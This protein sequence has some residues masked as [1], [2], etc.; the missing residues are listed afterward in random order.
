MRDERCDG[1]SNATDLDGGY[2]RMF[3]CQP[4]VL[5]CAQHD[6]YAEQRKLNGRLITQHP[7]ILAMM[8]RGMG[9]YY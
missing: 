6:K 4:S 3:E 1:C 9:G 2:C 5:P 7:H 8:I